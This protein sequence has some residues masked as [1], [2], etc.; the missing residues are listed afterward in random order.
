MKKRVSWI[1]VSFVL[2][3]SMLLSGCAAATPTA[4]P[5]A[6]PAATEV[7]PA[8]TEAATEAAVTGAATTIK[9]MSF[10]AYDNPEVEQA[11]V[12]AFEAKYPDIKVE[13]E[14]VPMSDIFLKYKTLIAGKVP[15]DVMAFNYDNAYQ[16]GAMGALEPLDS[17]I[18]ASGYDTSKIYTATLDMFKVNGV[19]YSM[20]ATFS[21]VVLYYNKALFDA[22]G[23]AY[24]QDGWTMED[25]KKAGLELTKDTNGD[26]TLDQF[27][28]AFPWW[29]VILE[30]YNAH[31]WDPTT[32]KCTLNSPE[33]IKAFQKIVDARYTEQYSPTVDQLAEQ[34]DWDMFIAGKLA[35]YPTGPWAV[36][37]FNDKITTFTYDIANMPAGDKQ[38]T[39]VYA[40]S[41]G[42]AAGSLNKDAAWKFIEFATGPEGTKIRQDGKYEIS[43]VKEIAEKYYVEN[44]AGDDPEHAIVFMEAMAYAV[45]QP[46]HAH[47]QEIYD[48]IAPELDLAMSGQK[49]VAEA[50]NA[51]CAGVDTVLA[52]P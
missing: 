44:L 29:P 9:V 7:A 2:V 5:A 31:I 33:A 17:Y 45:P 24:P 35:M 14:S 36:Q 50:L 16:F 48:A 46:V 51:A 43:P 4:A 42:M 39:H 6:D 22:A 10:F 3:M 12:A 1:V 49:D 27:G 41:Y 8:A 37:P 28:Y 26:G 47:W 25:V 19:Q 34:G 32:N 11:V 23:L 13:F 40:N 20:P 38:A 15:P 52:Q 18:Q 30:M 21:D